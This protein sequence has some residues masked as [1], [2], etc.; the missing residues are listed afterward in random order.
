MNN[1]KKLFENGCFLPN[2]QEDIQPQKEEMP[3]SQAYSARNKDLATLINELSEIKQHIED[4]RE[5]EWQL[6]KMLN[7]HNNN[8]VKE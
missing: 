5:R 7:F 1:E 4:V 8:F 2:W 3:I 6:A